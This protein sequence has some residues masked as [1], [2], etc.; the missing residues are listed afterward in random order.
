MVRT[1]EAAKDTP[2]IGNR[3]PCIRFA[4]IV[5]ISF[6]LGAGLLTP[7][8]SDAGERDLTFDLL[9]KR[10]VEDGFDATSIGSI[11]RRS[12]VFF[13]IPGVTGFFRHSEARLNY[14]QFLSK[15]SIRKAQ[16]YMKA[17]H[18]E[19]AEAEG[20]YG[21]EKEIITAI[22]LVE[23]RLGVY[24]GKNSVVN[25]LST[26]ASLSDPTLREIFW[27]KIPSAKRFAKQA[28]EDKAKKKSLWAY[29]ELTAFLP[30][31]W[32]EG[33]DPV[34]TQGSYAGALGIPQFIPTSIVRLARDGDSDGHIDLFTHA[35]AIASVA[36]Y[37]KHH[38]W[39]AGIKK[40]KAYS[41][42][43]KY[44]YS[45]PYAETLLKIFERLKG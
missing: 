30:Y 3:L 16:Q 38:K 9:R 22:L 12:Q 43:L 4:I 45:R 20:T 23:T 26:L 42:L 25:T 35:D 41:V 6:A 10:L 31:A 40:K 34:K 19:L 24:V 11:Y 7:C 13:D 17:F 37:L 27:E 39:H 2:M 33:F 28:Y 21:V 14:K 36:N 18:T 32:K 44:N 29:K 1:R 8:R 5:F 15:D